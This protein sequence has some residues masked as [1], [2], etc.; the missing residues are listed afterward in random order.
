M[1]AAPRQHRDLAVEPGRREQL[2]AFG[3]RS[4]TGSARFALAT[5]I[6]DD[7]GEPSRRGRRLGFDDRAGIC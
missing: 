7:R 2:D 4:P 5:C 6:P 3:R 1:E